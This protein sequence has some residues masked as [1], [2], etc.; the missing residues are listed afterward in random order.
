[1]VVTHFPATMA[2]SAIH[3]PSS[4]PY[5]LSTCAMNTHFSCGRIWT[6][7][8]PLPISIDSLTL[9]TPVD[10]SLGICQS[11]GQRSCCMRVNQS[12]LHPRS[13]SFEANTFT[14]RFRLVNFAV[15]ASSLSLPTAT[16]DSLRV[17]I[18]HPYTTGLSPARWARLCLAH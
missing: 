6:S 15:Y 8:V 14:F 4:P 10:A 12:H 18:G 7:Q 5:V 9:K 16:Q 2:D 13:F 17:G 3:T 1:M 11:S